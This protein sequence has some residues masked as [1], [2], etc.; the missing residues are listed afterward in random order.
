MEQWA[1]GKLHT[2]TLSHALGRHSLL[3]PFF[4][5]GP[6]PSA[7]DGA[8]L[9]MGFYRHSNPYRHIVGP[10]LR[11]IVELGDPPRSRFVL[12]GGQSG[13]PFSPHYADQ[14]ELWRRGGYIHPFDECI[15]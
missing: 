6:L 2:L 13:H 15:E 8:T 3:E 10:S 14:F 4:S 12:A 9:N 1:W 5:I 11:M 7:G